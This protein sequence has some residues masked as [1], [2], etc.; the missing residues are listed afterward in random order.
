MLDLYYRLH[1]W[2][3]DA[4]LNRY[5]SDP[6]SIDIIMERRKSLEWLLDSASD[7]DHIELST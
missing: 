1:W 6:V 5:P 3:R 4:Q 2:V 7:W